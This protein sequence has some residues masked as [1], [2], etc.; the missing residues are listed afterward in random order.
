[1][2][3]VVGLALGTSLDILPVAWVAGA[4]AG[5]VVGKVGTAT[6]SV[7]ELAAAMQEHVPTQQGVVDEEALVALV[8][9]ARAAG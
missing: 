2:R 3:L 5:V 9:R 6:V 7:E 1:M 4:A 8:S